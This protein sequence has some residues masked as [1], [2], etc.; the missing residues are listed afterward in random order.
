LHKKKRALQSA[1]L[2]LYFF[3]LRKALIKVIIR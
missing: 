2:F 3:D 1:R